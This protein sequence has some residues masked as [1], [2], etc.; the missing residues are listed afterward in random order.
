M[1]AAM[2]FPLFA[3]HTLGL[4]AGRAQSAGRS[5]LWRAARCPRVGGPDR[6]Q[7]VDQAPAEI[8]VALLSR[9]EALGRGGQDAAHVRGLQIWIALEHQGDNAADFGG[10]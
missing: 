2:L 7:R 9:A 1:V 6:R 4:E 5:A 8:V 10:L 3:G